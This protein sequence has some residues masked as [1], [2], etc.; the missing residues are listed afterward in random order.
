MAL[1]REQGS[2]APEQHIAPTLSLSLSLSLIVLQKHKRSQPNLCLSLSQGAVW[3][4]LALFVFLCAVRGA[5]DDG[6]EDDPTHLRAYISI[7]LRL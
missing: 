5:C 3:L 7:A 6:E 1:K 2:R 4:S